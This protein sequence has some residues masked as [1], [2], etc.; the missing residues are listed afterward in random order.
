MKTMTF[1][2]R[3][4]FIAIFQLCFQMGISAQGWGCISLPAN[5]LSG[6]D[7][8][9]LTTTTGKLTVETWVSGAGILACNLDGPQNGFTINYNGW[10]EI[11]SAGGGNDWFQLNLT[12]QNNT[13]TI[14]EHVAVV[15][16][17]TSKTFYVNGVK[18]SSLPITTPFVSSTDI[19]LFLDHNTWVSTS[20]SQMKYSDFRIWNTARTADEILANFQSHVPA[21]S[22]GLLINYSFDEQQGNTTK[23][24]VQ[25]TNVA[26]SGLLMN[27]GSVQYEWG[28]IG[29]VP[30]NLV[31]TDKTATSFKLS[32][33]GGLD[34]TWD[35]EID[36]P[37]GGGSIDSPIT[38][39][40]SIID[41]TASS[42]TVKVR[43]TYPILTE[44]SAPTII[45]LT[46]GIIKNLDYNSTLT[47]QNGMITINNLE[48]AND[49]KIYNVSGTLV[50]QFKSTESNYKINATNLMPG[51]YLFKVNNVIKQKVFKVAI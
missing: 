34:N 24:L 19:D 13:Y 17:A 16:D 15:F 11:T 39:S 30:T 29:Q 20:G 14:W 44:W 49:I 4:A 45:N 40:D 25:P 47:N 51:L 8:G 33:D 7:C 36:D 9:V 27:T 28:H 37:D 41:L 38:N 6:V 10:S 50:K 35:V 26:N 22:P 31:V 32:W 42:Y 5:G 18:I 23:N 2:N 1:F 21:T 3:V 43:A 48:G 12:N 46:T